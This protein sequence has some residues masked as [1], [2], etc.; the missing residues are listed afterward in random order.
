M[1]DISNLSDTIVP[2]SDQLNSEQLLSGPMTIT[3]TG[4]KRGDGEQP[5]VVHYLGEN[6]RPYK[7]CKT[8]RKV[9][10]FAWGEDGAKWIGRAMTL[11]NDVSVK[12]AGVAVGGIRISHLSHIDKDIQMS[13]TATRGKKDPVFI[14]KL[15]VKPAQT[16]NLDA[17]R[18]K[19]K[20]VAESGLVALRDYWGKVSPRIKEALTQQWYDSMEEI[21]HAA[22]LK[23]QQPEI[24]DEAL[25]EFDAGLNGEQL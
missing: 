8:M 22:D 20:V 3:V 18:D 14:R 21:A 15:E 19:I 10:I 5:I 4:V 12:W 17:W 11:Y 1:S 16:A 7:P 9:L 24:T 23:A 2:K 13:L 6:G 25:A